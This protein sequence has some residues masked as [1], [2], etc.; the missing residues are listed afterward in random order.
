M[1]QNVD[2][3]SLL[4]YNFIEL[5]EQRFVAIGGETMKLSQKQVTSLKRK[6]GEKNLTINHL[7]NE[8]GVS[9]FTISRIIHNGSNEEITPTTGKKVN[10][11]LI[12]EYN[13][14]LVTEVN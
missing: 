2:S 6:R 7:A 9:R 10:D 8:I 5:S 12:N 3:N 13:H 11:W 1:Q 4:L 14:D